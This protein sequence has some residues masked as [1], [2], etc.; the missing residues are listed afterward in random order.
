MQNRL[1]KT[2]VRKLAPVLIAITVATICSLAL[3]IVMATYL[4]AH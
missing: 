2:A 1:I 3:Q 4:I